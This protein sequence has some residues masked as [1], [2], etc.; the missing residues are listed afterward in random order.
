MLILAVIFTVLALSISLFGLLYK[1]PHSTEQS[2][3]KPKIKKEE[4]TTADESL[5]LKLQNQISLLKGQLEKA[6]SD[7]SK[8]QNEIREKNERESDLKDELSKQI[9]WCKRNEFEL[10][11]LKKDYLRLKD[12]LVNKEKDLESKI[13]L[14]LNLDRELSEKKQTLE[15]LERQNRELSD[16]IRF[17]EVKVSEYKIQWDE[18]ER[19][20]TELKEKEKE[21]EWVSK[22]EYFKLK[23]QLEEKERI[24]ERL[25]K[26]KPG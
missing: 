21:S 26:D 22:R 5:I 20:I 16:K 12:E 25:Q 19:I 14:N 9:E 1:P 17:L 23:R 2:K 13:S 4:K 11:K 6:K 15:S 7:Y 18:K 3:L 24:L 10:E 8:I